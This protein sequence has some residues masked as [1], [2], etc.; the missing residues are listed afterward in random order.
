MITTLTLILSALLSSNLFAGCAA[1]GGPHPNPQ[2][3]EVEKCFGS[4]G[5]WR[6]GTCELVSSGGGGG[7]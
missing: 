7:Y 4:G 6:S 3:S 2:Y 1:S 5:V